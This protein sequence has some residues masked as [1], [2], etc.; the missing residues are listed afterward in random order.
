MTISLKKILFVCTGNSCR[1]V[2]AEGLLRHLLSE[3]GH[4]DIQVLSAGVS[5]MAGF[6]PTQETVEVM[7]KEGIDVSGHMGQP[8]TRELVERADAIFC[9][10]EFHREMILVQIP[11]AEQKV[12]LLKTFQLDRPMSDPNVQDPI[13]RSKEVYESCLLTIKQ[14]VERVVNW[15]EQQK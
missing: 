12:Y 14:A 3:K 4:T 1:S 15:L 6:G 11:A 9:M 2:M 10:E 7:Q 5:A 8:V 13:G